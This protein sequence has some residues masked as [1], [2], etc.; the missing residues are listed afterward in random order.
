MLCD[1][2]LPQFSG[3]RALAL[4]QQ[5]DPDLPFVI[6]SGRIGEEAAV[7]AMHSGADD[8]V[9]KDRISRLGPA[10]RRAIAYRRE[11]QERRRAE[12]ADRA[13]SV[14]LASMSH[15][16]RTPLNAIIGFSSLLLTNGVDDLTAEQR[17]QLEIIQSSGH[18]LLA[19]ITN[20]LDISRI[21]A[22]ALVLHPAV[23]RL[24]DVLDEQCEAAR[25]QAAERG[26]E[27]RGPACDAS[28][29]VLADPS[30]LRQI[31]GNLLVNAIKFTDHGSIGVSAEGVQDM[32]RVVIQDTG[33]GIPGEDLGTVFDLFSRG[34]RQG[35]PSREGTGLGLAICKRLVDAMGGTIGVESHPGRGS[36]FWFTVPLAAAG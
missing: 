33:V 2:R 20:L 27:L 36:W 10:V 21:E 14:F 28:I 32:A 34:A 17:K 25:L 12:S 6:V 19:L 35:D 11:L 13:K 7:D 4:K 18:Q 24:A 3:E 31:I 8:Y 29:V 26:L 30:R 5:L 15:D 16:L 22:G 9:L 1:W 23:L